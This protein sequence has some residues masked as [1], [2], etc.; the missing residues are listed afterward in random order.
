MM[1]IFFMLDDILKEEI[2]KQIEKKT[3]LKDIIFDSLSPVIYDIFS[4]LKEIDKLHLKANTVRI[5]K[6]FHD[7]LPYMFDKT[8]TCDIIIQGFIDVGM[9]DARHNLWPN[10]FDI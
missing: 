7:R 2:G 10:F 6:Y 4:E 1:V 5:L 8:C 3:T 9:L